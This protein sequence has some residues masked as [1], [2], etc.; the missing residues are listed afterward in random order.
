MTRTFT[1]INNETKF[2]TIKKIFW[3][4]EAAELE[5]FIDGNRHQLTITY[6]TFSVPGKMVAK[7]IEQVEKLYGNDDDV[8]VWD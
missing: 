8:E 2:E 1:V 6:D 3:N 7:N 5:E 4:N